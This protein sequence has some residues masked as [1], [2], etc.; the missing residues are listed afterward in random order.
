MNQWFSSKYIP[1]LYL[2]VRNMFY[3]SERVD[4]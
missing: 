1:R 3:M 4:D 2:K